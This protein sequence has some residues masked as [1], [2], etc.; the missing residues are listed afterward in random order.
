[1]EMN[2]RNKSCKAL[3]CGS[4]LA[5]PSILT[6]VYLLTGYREERP[7]SREIPDIRA[8]WNPGSS[9]AR[10]F[11]RYVGRRKRKG[12]KEEGREGRWEGEGR[13]R[14][15]GTLD[16]VQSWVNNCGLQECSIG[17][18]PVGQCGNT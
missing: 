18:I 17:R 5:C 12:E 11:R 3:Y 14:K 8:V 7:A 15:E 13:V 9:S 6:G 1:M 2:N 16:G 4:I 10:G